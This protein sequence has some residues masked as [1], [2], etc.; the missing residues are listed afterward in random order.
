MVPDAP[1]TA[2]A[3]VQAFFA[4]YGAHDIDRM[5]SLCSTTAQ[6]RHVP[7]GPFETGFAH[8]VG[9]KAW[10]G[11]FSAFPDLSVTVTSAFS[12]NGHVGA[13]VVIGDRKRRFRLP[14][15]YFL[16]VD[17]SYRITNVT[18]YWDNVNLGFQLTK[19]G[20]VR[21]VSATTR[22]RKR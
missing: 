2:M 6:L 4:A 21:L 12:D 10:S 16:T 19:A 5:L 13:E 11:M 20:V 15:A 18:V 3:T 22:Q 14:Q 1:T 9:R 17:E 8:S 7:M